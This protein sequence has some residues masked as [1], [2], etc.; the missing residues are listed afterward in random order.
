MWSQTVVP[1]IGLSH[2]LISD[3][4]PLFMSKEFQEWLR[5]MGI[6]HKVS[7]PYHPQTDRQSERKNKTIIPMFIAEKT[8]EINWVKAT[9]KV[10]TQVNA[11]ISGPRKNS[12][13]FSVY[14]F[15]PKLVAS[16]LPHPIP[17]Y[18][19]PTQIHYQLG[20]N[21]TEAKLQ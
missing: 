10:H 3:Q 21:L 2:A 20:S 11:R 15:N 12:P 4:D 9:P 8:K 18:S 17:I 14:G 7:S 1:I 6:E 13:F 5:T 19:N 16:L